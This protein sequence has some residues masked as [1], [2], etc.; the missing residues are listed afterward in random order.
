VRIA[1]V[2]T[3]IRRNVTRRSNRAMAVL[4]L[5]DFTGN[6]EIV[7]FP[8]VLEANIEKIKKDAK[9][10][11]TAR[12]SRREDE[13]PKFLAEEVFTVEDAK[14]R[15]AKMLLIDIEP[16][17]CG[18]TTLH[19][20]EDIFAQHNGDVEVLFRLKENG[21]EKYVRSRRYKLSTSQDVLRQIRG[22]LG[23][24]NVTCLWS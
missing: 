12:V 9:L 5:E 15:F 23:D 14:A 7:V 18:P 17:F 4:T 21:E 10:V 11:I 13:N 24:G 16:C 19:A 2:V 1:G 22:M 8:D 3:D 6:G 20:L